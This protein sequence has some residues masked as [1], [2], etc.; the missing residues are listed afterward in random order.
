MTDPPELD[1]AEEGDDDAEGGAVRA[2]CALC[3]R[4]LP[5]AERRLR[6]CAMCDGRTW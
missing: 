6:T 1:D 3:G 2:T 5:P 4:D